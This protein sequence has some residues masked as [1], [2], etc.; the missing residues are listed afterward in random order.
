MSFCFS[1]AVGIYISFSNVFVDIPLY[2]K[3]S[4]YC[5]VVKAGIIT[6]D[7]YHVCIVERGALSELIKVTTGT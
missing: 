2:S 1:F 3:C 4:I 6:L 7:K 5:L